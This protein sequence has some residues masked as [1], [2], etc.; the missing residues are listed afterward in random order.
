VD[1]NAG[2]GGFRLIL[3]GA[4][5]ATVVDDRALNLRSELAIG[6]FRAW[7]IGWNAMQLSKYGRDIQRYTAGVLIIPE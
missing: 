6:Q 1:S 2:S 7:M 4:A 3:L 5:H